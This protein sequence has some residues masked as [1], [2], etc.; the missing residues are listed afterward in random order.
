MDSIK[1]ALVANDTWPRAHYNGSLSTYACAIKDYSAQSLHVCTYRRIDHNTQTAHVAI[2]T[3]TLL[4][5]LY[6][7]QAVGEISKMT[8]FQRISSASTTPAAA[9]TYHITKKSHISRRKKPRRDWCFSHYRVL[10]MTPSRVV[11]SSSLPSELRGTAHSGNV[12]HSLF[13]AYDLALPVPTTIQRSQESCEPDARSSKMQQQSLLRQCNILE[14]N[15]STT[16]KLSSTPKKCTRKLVESFSRLMCFMH[17]AAFGQ[18]PQDVC[19]RVNLCL[20]VIKLGLDGATTTSL[21]PRETVR[22]GKASR[23]AGWATMPPPQLRWTHNDATPSACTS[24]VEHFFAFNFSPRT[25]CIT[26]NIALGHTR[27]VHYLGIE[28]KQAESVKNQITPELKC[29]TLTIS[30]SKTRHCCTTYSGVSSARASATNTNYIMD[31][32]IQQQS[33]YLSLGS[34]GNEASDALTA[35]QSPPLNYSY[36]YEYV[37]PLTARRATTR[38][39]VDHQNQVISIHSQSFTLS[40]K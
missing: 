23:D 14:T 10:S 13:S 8:T 20:Y 38:S 25:K 40:M 27:S 2:F 5:S 37:Y 29:D 34:P 19:H 26:A 11:V 22:K 36:L 24:K 30:A 35:S 21:S 6:E 15:N 1:Y 32:D 9:A 18:E 3:H 12:G 39:A 4:K 31:G 17:A 7:K 16:H 28:L 33:T